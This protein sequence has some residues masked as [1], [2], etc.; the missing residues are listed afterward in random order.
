MDIHFTRDEL[1]F[2]DEVRA[3]LEQNLSKTLA[4][5]VRHGKSIS[6]ADNVAWMRTLNN[7]GWLAA[8]WP[9]EHGGTGWTAVQK[10]IFDE[11][12]S[13]AGAPRII[14]FGINMVGPVICKFGTPE[15]QAHFLPRI[16][17]CEDWWCQGYSEPGAGSDL[18]SLN[19]RA[20]R[21]GEFYV[22]NGQ[23]TWT[24]T[25][26]LADWMFCLVRTDAQAQAQRGISFLLIDMKSPGVSVRPIITLDGGHHVNEV[27]LDNVRVP[28]RNLVGREHEG[29]TCAKYLLTHERTTIAGIGMAKAM[30]QRLK[31]AAQIELRNG[32]PMIED[33]HFRAQVAEVEMQLMAIDMSNLRILAAARDGGV[34]GAESSILKIKGTEIRQA[35]TY[36]Q[37]KVVGNYALP[38]LESELGYGHGEEQLHNDFSATATCQYLEMRKA[39]V[40]GGSNEIQKNIIAKMILEL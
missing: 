27:F 13:R 6:K 3:F 31:Q 15:Q 21:E 38:Y 32:K 33:A 22:V 20:V 17:A 30:L 39:S 7:K 10:H 34:P 29:W 14:P 9:V 8:S 28:V 35:I 5:R 37:S 11:E 2:R 16:L 23:K 19:T 24:S 25:A 1:A 40:Y 18:A 4:E 12:Y 36:L 26:H